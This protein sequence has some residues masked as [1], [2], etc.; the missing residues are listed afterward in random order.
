VNGDGPRYF[1]EVHETA[2]PDYFGDADRPKT[3]PWKQQEK[4]IAARTGDSPVAGSGNQPGRPGDT[5]GVHSLR[6]AKLI[7][8]GGGSIKAEWLSK[9]VEQ[10]LRMNRRPVLEVRFLHA[11]M[12]VP[13][14]WV[15]VPATD[16]DD[17]E[18]RAR[19][20]R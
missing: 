5:M 7:H 4:D 19:G 17:L 10:A 11:E 2:K 1:D 14:D 13:R 16:Y 8:G 9:L 3:G 15:L 6:E 12:P 20:N 18:E